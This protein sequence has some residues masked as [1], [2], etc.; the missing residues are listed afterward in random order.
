MCGGKPPKP[1]RTDPQADADR[2]SESLSR[3]NT[4]YWHKK[5]GSYFG[6]KQWI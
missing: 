5:L 6:W 3:G 2:W 4:E 1:V